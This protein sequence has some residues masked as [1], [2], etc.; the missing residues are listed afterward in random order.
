[1]AD[2]APF[3]HQDSQGQYPAFD[4]VIARFGPYGTI[5]ENI[6]AAGGTG[7]AF[8]PAAYRKRAADEWMASEEHRENILS[9]DFNATGI[10]VVVKGAAAYATQVFR[11][12]PPQK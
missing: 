7:R 5:G 4:M 9:R 11:G 3:S 2:G 1:M 8:D 10:G 6:F 12:P